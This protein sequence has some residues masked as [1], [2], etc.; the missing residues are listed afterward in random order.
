MR[1]SGAHR[2]LA[3]DLTR[4]VQYLPLVTEQRQ[5][6]GNPVFFVTLVA[7]FGLRRQAKKKRAYSP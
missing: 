2:S 4:G 3:A 7:L 6:F 5:L 1:G